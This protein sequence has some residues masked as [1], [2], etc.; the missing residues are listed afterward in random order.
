MFNEKRFLSI[1]ENIFVF[2]QNL[3]ILKT[4]LFP[5]RFFHINKYTNIS[6]FTFSEICLM[7]FGSQI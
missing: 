6:L 5:P 3:F 7:I 2:N 4:F 1:K